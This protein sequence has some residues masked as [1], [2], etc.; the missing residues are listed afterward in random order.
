MMIY[1]IW[2][3][4]LWFCDLGEILAQVLLDFLYIVGSDKKSFIGLQCNVSHVKW[5]KKVPSFIG[6]PLLL[7]MLRVR[8]FY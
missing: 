8:Q 7:V 3:L 4:P 5:C 1:L 2:P 6:P